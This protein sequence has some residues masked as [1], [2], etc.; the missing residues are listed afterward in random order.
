MYERPDVRAH[1]AG[2][3]RRDGGQR[4]GRAHLP[5]SA[6]VGVTEQATVAVN[7]NTLAATR[8]GVFAAGDAT[9]GTAFIVEAVA[10]G[11]R[12]AE[13]IPAW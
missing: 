4:A 11:H 13:S 3:T 2:P 10:A 5:E 12:V 6:G 7:P 8:P 1:R 9:T